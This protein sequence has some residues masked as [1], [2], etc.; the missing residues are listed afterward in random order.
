MNKIKKRIYFR[1]LRH[2][3]FLLPSVMELFT[4]IAVFWA[5]LLYTY[6]MYALHKRSRKKNISLM[7]IKALRLTPPLELNGRHNFFF[8]LK[9]VMTGP[10]P[11]FY[12]FPEHEIIIIYNYFAGKL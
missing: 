2:S 12:G 7:A 5:T 11:F 4:E 6:I 3:S 8:K 9:K 1:T 10:L